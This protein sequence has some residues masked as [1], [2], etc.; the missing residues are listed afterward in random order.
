MK[1][2]LRNR[3]MALVAFFAVTTTMFANNDKPVEVNQLPKTAQQVI[4]KH[5]AGMEVAMATLET[6]I[7][8]KEYDVVFTDG[9]KIEFDRK[10]QWT[11][12]E[13]EK[14]QVPS[15]LVPAAIINYVK[16]KYKGQRILKIEKDNREYEIK[17]SNGLEITFN[18]RFKVLEID[19]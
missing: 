8:D 5:F 13:C 10:G 6:G 14:S 9:N 12:I 17:L 1:A 15:A 7:M 18:K 19:K 16:D 11:N 3:L 2:N 4:N